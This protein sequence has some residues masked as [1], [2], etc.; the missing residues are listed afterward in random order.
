MGII[1]ILLSAVIAVAAAALCIMYWNA[2]PLVMAL[3]LPLLFT[4][5]FSAGSAV[6]FA[7]LIFDSVYGKISLAVNSATV[8]F[9]FIVFLQLV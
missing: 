1:S 9:L 8:V 6:F 2:S 5:T 3:G 7:V 4:V